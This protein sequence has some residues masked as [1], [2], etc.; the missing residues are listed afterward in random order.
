M[1]S[2]WLRKRSG[3]RISRPKEAG[4]FIPP[5]RPGM[6]HRDVYFSEINWSEDVAV[7]TRRN[8][9]LTDDKWGL[10]ILRHTGKEP[11]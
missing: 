6:P 8:I 2:T 1:S 3:T 4:Y 9:F 10:F 5:E 7:D 11:K